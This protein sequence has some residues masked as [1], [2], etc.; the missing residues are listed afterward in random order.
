MPCI[1]YLRFDASFY[2]L[3]NNIMDNFSRSIVALETASL[4]EHIHSPSPA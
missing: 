2:L 3:I 4:A 1:H